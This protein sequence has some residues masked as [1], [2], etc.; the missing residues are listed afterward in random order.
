MLFIRTC[1]D[2]DESSLESR[3][4][5]DMAELGVP[6]G[7]EPDTGTVT[8]LLDR[9]EHCNAEI[10]PKFAP[11]DAGRLGKLFEKLER[12]CCDSRRPNGRDQLC[13]T[14]ESIDL[15]ALFRGESLP[16]SDGSVLLGQRVPL[17]YSD[18]I[19]GNVRCP[20]CRLVAHVADMDI[21]IGVK[22]TEFW[23]LM[24][25][26]GS[27]VL[28]PLDKGNEVDD[29]DILVKRRSAA[30]SEAIYLA[31]VRS[32]H[33]LPSERPRLRIIMDRRSFIG[34][35]NQAQLTGRTALGIRSRRSGN[36]N[37]DILRRWLDLCGTHKKCNHNPRSRNQPFSLRVL[38][39][40]CLQLVD[41]PEHSPY[42]SLSYVL[43]RTP[44]MKQRLS[45]VISDLPR[46]FQDAVTVT[47]ALGFRYIWTDYLCV[48]TSDM[49]QRIFDIER[50]GSIY[51]HAHVTIIDASN[52]NADGSLDGV[53]RSRI[54]RQHS[55]RI[56]NMELL[57]SI[58]CPKNMFR[59]SFWSQRG[60]TFQ[61]G[62][63]SRR[64]IA[65]GPEQVTYECAEETWCESMIEPN[66]DA[67]QLKSDYPASAFA[68]RDP[69]LD[70]TTDPITLYW[71]LVQEYTGRDLTHASDSLR[72]FDGFVEFFSTSR[73]MSFLSGV[74]C[75]PNLQLNLLWKHWWQLPTAKR[76][77][78]LPSWS[79]AGWAGHVEMPLVTDEEGRGLQITL[80]VSWADEGEDGSAGE[81][82]RSQGSHVLD[83]TAR[84]ADLALST[85]KSTS[86]AGD[87]RS[88]FR[89]DCSREEEKFLDGESY[90]YMEVYRRGEFTHGLL[91]HQP[92][93]GCKERDVF[94]RIGY[95]HVLI[96]T[97]ENANPQRKTLKLG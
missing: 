71:S 8:D 56:G 27:E 32:L 92:S 3:C 6:E 85:R 86:A 59:D 12:T 87:V 94:E 40:D 53:G 42:V 9:M 78:H 67:G 41:K 30:K 25:I 23:W 5:S 24:T 81:T 36:V 16:S 66:A 14:C 1:S 69:F 10:R 39:I 15:L 90:P 29:A 57:T 21:E 17:G 65:F 20:L 50:M 43:G 75:H 70:E 79:W 58:P 61:E 45:Y 22:M 63:M 48:E 33:R 28:A 13:Q 83:C 46:F 82:S 18:Q 51:R 52:P 31:L 97:F 2:V 26:S 47:R 96:W 88:I 62:L 72:A 89:L 68:L 73:G 7:I 76:R 74:P 77:L 84:V 38:D 93:G 49:A 91:L 34:L 55:E 19:Y 54:F 37:I 60:W 95:G 64:C 35:S 4:L 80:V 11:P 44:P